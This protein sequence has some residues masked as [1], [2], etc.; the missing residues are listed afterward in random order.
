VIVDVE[1]GEVVTTV[2]AVDAGTLTSPDVI[3]QIVSAVLRAVEEKQAHT[4]RV[5]AERRVTG[6]VSEERD[7]EE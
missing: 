2:K 5:R 1:I 6:G 3:R 7:A 4:D